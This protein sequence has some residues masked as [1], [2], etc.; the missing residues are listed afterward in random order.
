MNFDYSG[1]QQ[2]LLDSVLRYGLDNWSADKRLACLKDLPSN[3]TK[4]WAEMADLGWLMLSIPEEE[5]G[6]GGTPV[7]VMALMEGIGRHLIPVPYVTSCVLVPALLSGTGETATEILEGIG[8]G[9]IRAAAGFLES[10]GGFDLNYVGLSAELS[11]NRWL[12]SGEKVHVEDGG[13]ADWYVVSARTAGSIMDSDGISLFL[14]SANSPGLKVE[15]FRAV[16][17]HTHSRLRLDNVNATLVGEKDQALMR[18]ESAVDRAI[19]AH[20]AEAVAS[21]E[22]ANAVTLDYLGTRRQFGVSI[23]SFQVLQHRAVDMAIAAEEARSMMLHATLNLNADPVTR[24]RAVSAAKTRVGQTGLYV[25]KQAVQLHGGVGT[26]D[27]LIISHHLKRQMMLDTAYGQADY[28][29]TRF[30]NVS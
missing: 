16:D 9:N 11:D 15:N 22:M 8:L 5:G 30:A 10:E 19:T 26:C 21:M 13:D 23:G 27:E 2:M 12:L 29:R 3:V 28:H 6:L 20:V 14:I 4:S 7:D 1:E 17:G 25:A 18:I 24:K